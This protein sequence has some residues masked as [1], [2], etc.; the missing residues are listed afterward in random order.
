MSPERNVEI[1]SLATEATR[2]FTLIELIISVALLIVALSIALFAVIGSTGLIA[3]TDA[4]GAVSEGGRSVGDMI[5]RTV[6]N[7][8]IGAVIMVDSESNGVNE[9][10]RVKA[11]STLKSSVA[12]TTI[13]RAVVATSN[14][15]EKYTIN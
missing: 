1:E 14:G 8:P 10:I 9:A 7:A 2:G 12:C 6:D 11:F 4:R 13:G 15:E 5:R 3:K